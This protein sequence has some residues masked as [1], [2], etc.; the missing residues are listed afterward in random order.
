M[1][2]YIWKKKFVTLMMILL[3][4]GC[5]TTMKKAELPGNVPAGW[6]GS[7]NE[8]L[9]PVA[10]HLL[11]MTG[12]EKL[13]QLVREAILNNRDL[14]ATSLRLKAAELMKISTSSRLWPSISAGF[15]SDRNNINRDFITGQRKVETSYQAMMNMSWE[16]DLWGRLADDHAAS[17]FEFQ[18][19]E[20]DFQKAKDSL[21]ARVIQSWIHVVSTLQA[22][23]ISR[24]NVLLL[25]QIEQIVIQRF[26]QGAGSLDELSA[27]KTRTEMARADFVF[28]KEEHTRMVRI[29]EVLLGRYPRGELVLDSQLPLIAK[30]PVE[31]P[32]S[33]LQNRPDIQAALH[34]IS[35]AEKL[36]KSAK[37]ARLPDIRLS[38]DVSKNHAKISE[39]MGASAAWSLLGSVI[40]PI[41]QGG[42]LKAESLARAAEANALVED[43]NEMV[44]QAISEVENALSRE[45]SLTGQETAL[46]SALTESEKSSAYFEQRYRGGL[47]SIQALLLAREQEMNIRLRHLEVHTARLSNRIDL[48]LAMGICYS[49]NEKNQEDNES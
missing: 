1:F 32:V 49:R 28:K 26:R 36:E 46:Q 5:A 43:L 8:I 42:R 13:K 7:L 41:F 23:R 18:A 12:D 39:L 3:L 45:K 30:P 9:H 4:S 6:T 34:R 21:A 17:E 2:G 25:Q 24:E 35:S 29:L 33:A 40:Q 38:A 19:R 11:D 47:E 44:L 15:S 20:Q 48:A 16:V 14:R 37:K 27:A 22:A 10:F 31:V